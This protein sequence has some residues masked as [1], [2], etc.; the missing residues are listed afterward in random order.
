MCKAQEW[1][2]CC[3]LVAVLAH[4]RCLGD[5]ISQPPKAES[6]SSGW[7]VLD[8]ATEGPHFIPY[9]SFTE[10]TLVRVPILLNHGILHFYPVHSCP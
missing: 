2:C 3:W 8:N 6:L 10:V 7:A 1:W 9:I 4:V 5:T